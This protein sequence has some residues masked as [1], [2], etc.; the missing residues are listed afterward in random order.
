MR[1]MYASE[2]KKIRGKGKI[3]LDCA[4]AQTQEKSGEEVG[5]IPRGDE[6]V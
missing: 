1:K 2:C 6:I 3:E 5:M 4:A